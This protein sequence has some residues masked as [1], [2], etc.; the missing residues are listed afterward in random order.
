MKKSLLFACLFALCALLNAQNTQKTIKYYD[1]A[2]NPI[3]NK[4]KA[5]YYRESSIEKDTLTVN[6]YYIKGTIKMTG[7]FL[8]PQ[9]K[10]KTGQ[11][12]YYDW[13]GNKSYER[14]YKNNKL[15]GS[16]K[17]FYPSGQLSQQGQ[18]VDDKRDGEWHNYNPDGTLEHRWI[19]ENDSTKTAK[20]LARNG[21]DT[22][23]GNDG[24]TVEQLPE[25]K[26]GQE[27]MMRHFLKALNYPPMAR[28][29]NIQGR[30]VLQFIVN[31][32]GVIS[33]IVVIMAEDID[34]EKEAVRVVEHMPTW[35]PGKKNGKSVAFWFTLP[36]V[37]KLD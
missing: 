7:M 33:D 18:Y 24:I 20:L 35:E 8:E 10:T 21:A 34:L 30:V 15:N 11:F 9:A 27:A 4:N 26:G 14:Q 19:C 16:W 32:D 31:K 22:T 23:S 28:E 2:W 13:N 6:D 3:K 37:F 1:R 29:N 12:V 36:I 17:S 5:S 25:F